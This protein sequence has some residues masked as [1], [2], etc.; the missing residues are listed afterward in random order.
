M[1]VDPAGA[2]LGQ[3]MERLGRNAVSAAS[4]LSLAATAA[5]NAAL[6]AA[7]VAIR[8]SAE[9][10]LDA[11]A[12]D[13]SAARAAKLGGA[14]LERLTLDE[15]RIEAMARGIEDVMALP[16]PIGTIA[17]EWQRPNGLRIQRVRVPLG[18]IGII[19]ESRP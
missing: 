9:R 14:L 8:D 13:L 10:I 11:N 12:A 3:L 2:D 6:A 7:A 19:Y 18:V 17:A 16:D 5:K 15:R 1:S 4:V